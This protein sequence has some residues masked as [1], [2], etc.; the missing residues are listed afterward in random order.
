MC[1]CAGLRCLEGFVK[2]DLSEVCVWSHGGPG[3]QAQAPALL[4]SGGNRGVFSSFSVTSCI[5][6]SVLSMI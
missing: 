4:I 3:A 6:H 2:P 1:H 5:F